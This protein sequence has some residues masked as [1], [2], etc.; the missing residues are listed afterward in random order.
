MY[1]NIWRTRLRTL[2]KLNLD[3]SSGEMT[4]PAHSHG[5]MPRHQSVPKLSR[6]L[7]L[8]GYKMNHEKLLLKNSFLKN[9]KEKNFV[10]NFDSHDPMNAFSKI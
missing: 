4:D 5:H 1:R 9:N 6:F 10:N 3:L 2:V 8:K 7:G